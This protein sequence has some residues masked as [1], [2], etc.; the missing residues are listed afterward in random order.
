MRLQLALDMLSSEAALSMAKTVEP[1]VDIIEVGTPLLKHEGISVVKLLRQHFP[2]KTILVDL[3]TMDVG[4]YEAD[5]AF[6]AGAD[7]V[8]VLGVADD[9][10]IAGAIASAKICGKAVVVDLINVV[11]K[12]ARA[13][14]S[15]ALGVQFVAVH[16]GIDQQHQGQSPLTDL[17]AVKEAVSI[18]VLVAGGIRLETLPRVLHLN[19]EIVV[20]G[21]AITSV[22]DP[23]AVARAICEALRC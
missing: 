15:Q 4:K 5:F 22:A 21:G 7:M 17:L 12:P 14:Q 9:S 20:V 1:Y 16:S 3:K 23:V 6:D 13:R 2:D 19:P 10:T 8:T 11:D 18:G